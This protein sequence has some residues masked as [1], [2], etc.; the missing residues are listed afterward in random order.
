MSATNIMDMPAMEP[1][2][3]VVPN[4][5]NPPN[6]NKMVLAVVSV[7]LIVSSIAVI[8][9]FYLKLAVL[10]K[11]Q[12][13]DYFLLAAFILYIAI[14]IM[15]CRLVDYP[16]WYVHMWDVRMGGMIEFLRVGILTTSMFLGFLFSIKTAILVEW[17]HI[18]L[19]NGGNRRNLFFWACHFVIWANIVFCIVIL[20]LVNLACVPHEYLW[21]RTIKGG[22][23]R[24]N[25]AYT[26]LS[27][28][29]F[30]F[31]TDIIILFI[32]QRI[33]WTL[34]M[35]HRRKLGVSIVF[36]LGMAA[37]AASIIRLYYTVARSKSVD[38][39]YHLS[40]VQL[41]AVGEGACVIL[42]MCMPNVPKAVAGLKL[43]NILPSIPSW[44]SLVS[45]VR[46]RSSQQSL[47][48]N[49]AGIAAVW[50]TSADKGGT[51][52]Q[53]GPGSE[54]YL[55]PPEQ[56]SSTKQYDLEM[57]NTIVRSTEIQ[58]NE[59]FGFDPTVAV[60]EHSRQHPWVER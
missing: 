31:A 33:I 9:R 13:Q 12:L 2:L 18:F 32:P 28:A 20:I 52:W 57:N 30:A 35:S 59:N 34:N 36:A 56:M 48:K 60:Q 26:S 43:T 8:L 22:Y 39:T 38:L 4:Y 16:G 42:V 40:T 27:A 55:V 29:C 53:N 11:M 1:P 10:R 47:R 14:L 54:R 41:T 23:C 44:A 25:T 46:L 24:I 7:C 45:V 58:T 5:D 15:Y 17:I 3:G 6:Q 21:N 19:P 49:A 51:N 37:C 50:P